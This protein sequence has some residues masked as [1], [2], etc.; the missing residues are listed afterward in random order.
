MKDGGGCQGSEVVGW[1]VELEGARGD[2]EQ[3]HMKV[4][5]G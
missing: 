1:E 5:E 3:G 2:L 4:I